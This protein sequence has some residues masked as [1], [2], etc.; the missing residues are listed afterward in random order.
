MRKMES[1]QRDNQQY[2]LVEWSWCVETCRN[3]GLSVGQWCQKNGIAV[4]TYFSWQKK[5]FQAL[6]EVREITFTEIPVM[7]EKPQFSGHVV[8][9][10]EISGVR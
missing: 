1:I 9:T 7:K 3:S 4:S 6:R 10:M 2:R 8:A 5:V